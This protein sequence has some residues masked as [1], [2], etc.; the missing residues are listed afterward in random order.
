MRDGGETQQRAPSARPSAPKRDP[1][2]A[3]VGGE[4]RDGGIERREPVCLHA[5]MQGMNEEI[6]RR[7]RNRG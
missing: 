6:Q 5:G 2:D 3:R 4:D 7:R 1:R